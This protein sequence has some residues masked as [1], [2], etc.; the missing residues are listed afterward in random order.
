MSNSHAVT[1]TKEGLYTQ[2]S[3]E[4]ISSPDQLRNYLRVTGAPIWIVLIAILFLVIGIFVWSS[5]VSFASYTPAVG[6]VQDGVMTVSLQD[7]K[8]SDSAANAD[9]AQL[10]VRVGDT[11]AQLAVS[12]RN[13]KGEVI[14]VGDVPLPDGTYDV[15]V[16]YRQTRAIELLLN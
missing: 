16:G 2:R 3:M 12:G 4:Q 11:E 13:A 1:E 15:R 14:A 6:R 7:S 5:F 9:A 8:I 10:Q